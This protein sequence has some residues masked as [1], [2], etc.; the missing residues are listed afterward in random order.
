MYSWEQT[1]LRGTVYASTHLPIILVVAAMRLWWW[2]FLAS[3]SLTAIPSRVQLSLLP[4]LLILPPELSN[5]D[6]VQVS[7]CTQYGHSVSLSTLCFSPYVLKHKTTRNDIIRER[8]NPLVPLCVHLGLGISSS[9]I[10]CYPSCL[11][12]TTTAGA[13]SSVWK[14]SLV[15]AQ[16]SL[17]A[18][19]AAPLCQRFPCH[20]KCVF[21]LWRAMRGL[22]LLWFVARCQVPRQF[23]DEACS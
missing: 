7:V 11:H 14:A 23:G 9:E 18:S 6:W 19:H 1:H 5:V 15:L 12:L 8:R 2:I 3:L 17:I 21:F 4:C 13:C 16:K 10:S 22:D 20:L